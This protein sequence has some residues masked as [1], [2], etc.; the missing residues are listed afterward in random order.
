MRRRCSRMSRQVWGTEHEQRLE[1]AEALARERYLYIFALAC[2]VIIVGTRWRSIFRSTYVDAT[3]RR[4]KRVWSW[5]ISSSASTFSPMTFR[6]S[7]GKSRD[8]EDSR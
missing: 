3:R 7:I 6:S 4:P 5:E 8:A 1:A 2:A